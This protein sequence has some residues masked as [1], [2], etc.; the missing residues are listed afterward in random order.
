[1]EESNNMVLVEESKDNMPSTDDE[2]SVAEI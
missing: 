1:V 2:E